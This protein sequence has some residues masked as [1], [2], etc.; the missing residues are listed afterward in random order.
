MCTGVSFWTTQA[1][2]RLGVPELTVSD[3]PHGLRRQADVHSITQKSLPATCFPT[4]SCLAST[5]NV[6]LVHEMGEALA[7]ECI[8]QKV[9]VILGPAVNMKRTPLVRAQFRVLL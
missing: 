9:D 8:A 7:E 1:V 6:D 2:E 3:G 5:W 4:A